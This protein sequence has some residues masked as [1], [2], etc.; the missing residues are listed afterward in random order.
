MCNRY[1]PASPD[2]IENYFATTPPPLPWTAGIGPW[3]R[4]PYVR[5]AGGGRACLV[6]QWGLVPVDAA[7]AVWP[8]GRGVLTNN[9]RWE[10]LAGKKT[11][12]GP[13]M[14][15]QRCLIPARSYDE[16]NWETGRNV[17]WQ[18]RRR[19][20]A[21][22]ALAGLWAEWADRSTGEVVPN[23]TMITI[24]CDGHPLL[25]RMHKPDP[26]LPPDKQDKRTVVPLEPQHWDTW[27]HGSIDEARQL[28]RVPALDLFEAGPAPAGAA[29][30]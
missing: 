23:Y 15:G 14:R 10:E 18:F 21:P 11:Y 22:W 8:Y 5:V 6:G 7:T 19:D 28:I 26:N 9:A 3:G 27:L 2:D 4:G 13:W 17:W 24:N 1:A 16:P 25:A 12:R 30:L 20:G 29:S